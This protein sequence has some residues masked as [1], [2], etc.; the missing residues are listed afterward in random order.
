MAI[1]VIT[2]PLDGSA[3]GEAVLPYA[4]DLAT[5]LNASIDL[6]TAV[7]ARKEVSIRYGVVGGKDAVPESERT[8]DRGRSPSEMTADAAKAREYLGNVAARLQA[9]GVKVSRAVVTGPAASSIIER[10]AE[11]ESSL[12]AMAT[13]GWTGIGHENVG[14]VTEAVLDGA[15]IIFP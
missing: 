15:T 9:Q 12:I 2:V 5:R 6:V 4:V 13:H 1:T 3:L 14:S 10:C 8:I 7:I 11:S